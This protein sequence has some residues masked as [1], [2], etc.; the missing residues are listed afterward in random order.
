MT[1][2][3]PDYELKRILGS[4]SFGTLQSPGYVFE[5]FD[6]HTNRRVAL[7]RIEKVGKTL[8][9]EYEILYDLKDCPHVVKMLVGR[10]DQDFFYS[11][12]HQNKLI[13]NIAFEYMEDN[14]ENMIQRKIEQNAYFAENHIKLM[15]YQIFEGLAFIHSKSRLELPKT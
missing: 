9:R 13:Q 15:V 10:F 2:T 8:S 3:L 4:G 14:L 12:N 11:R 6:H 5:A 7:K 1:A